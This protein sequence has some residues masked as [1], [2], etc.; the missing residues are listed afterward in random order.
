MPQHK[1]KIKADL[2]EVLQNVGKPESVC[3][4]CGL[5][6]KQIVSKTGSPNLLRIRFFHGEWCSAGYA[7]IGKIA[8]QADMDPDKLRQAL[9]SYL[10]QRDLTGLQSQIIGRLRGD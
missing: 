5:P 6:G 8:N 7:S 9:L 3:P 4:R 1:P 2:P 10:R